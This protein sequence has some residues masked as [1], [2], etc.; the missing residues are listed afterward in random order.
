M[1]SMASVRSG[2][3]ARKGW[4]GNRCKKIPSRSRSSRWTRSTSGRVWMSALAGRNA[5]ARVAIVDQTAQLI[6]FMMTVAPSTTMIW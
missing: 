6:S 4:L 1:L 2:N 3:A 5:V